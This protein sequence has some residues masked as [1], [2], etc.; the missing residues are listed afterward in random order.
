MEAGVLGRLLRAG[1]T[2]D[3]SAQLVRAAYCRVHGGPALTEREGTRDNHLAIGFEAEFAADGVAFVADEEKLEARFIEVG[4]VQLESLVV[5][6]LD[7]R[8][9]QKIANALEVSDEEV[10]P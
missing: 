10:A 7:S 5:T 1:Q 8:V 9:G 4:G 2:D 6:R 3:T